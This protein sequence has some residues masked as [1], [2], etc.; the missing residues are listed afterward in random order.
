MSHWDPYSVDGEPEGH[1]GTLRRNSRQSS[2]LRL[3]SG[4]SVLRSIVEPFNEFETDG[5]IRVDTLP[6]FLLLRGEL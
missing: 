6:R 5:I 4:G 2:C 3:W 1:D